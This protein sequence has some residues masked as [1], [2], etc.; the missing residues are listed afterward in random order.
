M[1]RELDGAKRIIPRLLLQL[2][3]RNC[4][5]GTWRGSCSLLRSAPETAIDSL[6]GSLVWLDST[7]IAGHRAGWAG[8]LV[9]AGE[10]VGGVDDLIRSIRVV[11]DAV[12]EGREAKDVC[13]RESTGIS[14]P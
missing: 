2:L 14:T 7:R 13:G 6:E 8:F 5:L 12:L 11:G 3:C 4:P 10:K 1:R 9:R